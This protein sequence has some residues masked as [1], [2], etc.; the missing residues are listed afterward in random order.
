MGNV[1]VLHEFR[2]LNTLGT[3]ISEF[4]VIFGLLNF[5]KGY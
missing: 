2:F 3:I 5:I 4:E 1:C